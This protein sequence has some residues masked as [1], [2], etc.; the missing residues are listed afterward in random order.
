MYS[1]KNR[2]AINNVIKRLEQTVYDGGNDQ[3]ISYFKMHN[4]RYERML[5]TIT[6]QIKEGSVVLDIGSHYLHSSLLLSWLGY[7][8]HPMDVAAFQNIDFVQK[9]AEENGL[10]QIEENNLESIHALNSC[11]NTYDLILF[12]EILEHITYNPIHF[13]EN[14]YFSLKPNGAIYISTPNSMNLFN[15][16]NSIRNIISLKRIGIPVKAIFENVTYGHHWKEYSAYEIKRYFS[17]LSPDF[18]VNIWG[19]RYR[20]YRKGGIKSFLLNLTRRLGNSTNVLAEEMEIIVKRTGSI[21]FVA[22]PPTY[23]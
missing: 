22:N 9:R 1:T 23:Y 8:I 16:L 19:Y 15:L 14:V 21:G 2:S 12:T 17:E 11:R 4:K 7:V 18:Q 6:S 20:E 3:D 5:H 13:W 10:K